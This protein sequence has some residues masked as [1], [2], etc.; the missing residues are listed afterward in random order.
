MKYIVNGGNKLFGRISVDAA[1]NSILPVIA[2]TIM[3]DEECVIKDIPLYL[4]VIEMS[5]I[6]EKLGKKVEVQNGNLVI[7]GE[8]RSTSVI[9]AETKT[10]RSSIFMMG[11]ILSKYRKAIFT[12]PGGCD[13]GK[14]PIDI[15]LEGLSKLGVKFTYANDLIYCDADKMKGN[16]IEL[17]FPSVGATE[18]LMMA[19]TLIDGEI[20]VIKNCAREPEIVDLANFINSMGGKVYGA[21]YETIVI[22]GVKKLHG[23]VYKC[24]MDRIATGT[25]LIAG[26]MCGGRIELTGTNPNYLLPLIVFLRN[27]GCKIDLFSDKIILEN[28]TRQKS[29]GKIETETY[30][31]FPTDLQSPVLVM[32]TI[33]KGTSIVHE[34]VFEARFKVVSELLKMGAK[35]NVSERYATIVGVPKLRPANVTCPDLRGGAGL[36]LAALAAKGRSEVDEIFHVER[37]YY[38]L[39]TNLKALGANIEKSE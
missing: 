23:T 32:Q 10:L 35:I 30:P 24:I 7:S 2:A 34:T 21:G 15:H 5:A 20:T 4:D 8:I 14:R 3:C 12:Y 38:N 6:L 11:S 29:I 27:S 33:S 25:Y 17:N 26:A 31:G 39:E 18:N 1:K 9:M 36:V 22:F 37:G 16:E 28:F 19:S 13:I